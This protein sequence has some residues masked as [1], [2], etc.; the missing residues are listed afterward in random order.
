MKERCDPDSL[1]KR[2]KCFFKL[3]AVCECVC[4]CE[5]VSVCVCVVESSSAWN[6]VLV[7]A[8]RCL[9]SPAGPVFQH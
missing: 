7:F 4:V 9:V 6:G 1:L 8:E 5:S 3:C 2:A